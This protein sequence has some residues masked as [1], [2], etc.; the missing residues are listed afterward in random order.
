MIALSISKVSSS[1]VCVRRRNPCDPKALFPP[2]LESVRMKAQKFQPPADFPSYE[3][4][5]ITVKP[6]ELK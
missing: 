1:E 3:G 6:E 2:T 5:P 4:Q